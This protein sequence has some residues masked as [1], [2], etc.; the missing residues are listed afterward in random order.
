M[1]WLVLILLTSSN[2]AVLFAQRCNPPQG[3][4]NCVCETEQGTIDLRPLYDD[5]TPKLAMSE[6]ITYLCSIMIL[7]DLKM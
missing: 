3:A 4:P 5:S 1:L 7:A 6:L 2:W